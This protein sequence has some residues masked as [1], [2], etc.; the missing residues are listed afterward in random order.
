MFKKLVLLGLSLTVI[1]MLAACGGNNGNNGSASNPPDSGSSGSASPDSGSSNEKVTLKIIHWI[2]EPVNKYYE[3]FNKKFTEKYPNIKV[4]Y[5]TVPSDATYDQLQQTRINA[6]DADLVALKSGFAP[7]PQEWAKGAEAPVW[8]QWIDA[9]LIMDLSGQDFVKNYNA[10]DVENST[11]YN[12]KVYGI[13]MG[14]VSFTGLFYNKKIFADNGLQVPKTWDEF[15]KVVDTLKSKGIAPL[16]FAGKDIWPFN[17]AVQ[18]LSATVHKDQAAFIKGLWD[19]S[20]KFTDPAQIEI[21]SKAQYLLQ[22]AIDGTMGVDYASLPSLFISGKVA[23]IADGTWNAPT[24]KSGD[25]SLEFGY[26]PIPGSNDAAQNASLAGKYDM[27]WMVLE[28]AKNKD[29]ALKWLAMQSEPDHYAEFVKASGFLPN[30]DVQIEDPFVNELKPYLQSFKLAWDQL[31][32][33]RPNAG[34]HVSGSS[35]HAEFLAPAGPIKT[36]DEL[37]AL[38]QKEWDA[39]APK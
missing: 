10:T 38:S 35:V 36:P 15:T 9:G 17:L 11:T 2:N 33:N 20:T 16:G 12:G 39:A 30:A 13:N 37:A 24:I 21:L 1:F 19:G 34:E 27:S 18:G 6:N 7:I 25:P 26:F 29:A 14:K 31:F 32:I 4:D 23:M 5:V 22:N 28:K 8:K 3:E